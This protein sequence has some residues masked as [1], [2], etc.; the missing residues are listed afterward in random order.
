MAFRTT[1]ASRMNSKHTWT[2]VAVAALLF[3]FIFFFERHWRKPEP[4][5]QPIL[6][7]LKPAAV[8]SIQVYPAGQPG[9][10]AEHTNGNWVLTEPIRYPAQATSIEAL[11]EAL[12]TLFPAAPPLTARELRRHPGAETEYGLENPQASLVIQQ[13]NDRRQIRFG[14]LTAPGDQVFMRVVGVEDIYIADAGILKFVP[15]GTNVWRDTV[16]VPLPSLDFDRLILTN[17]ASVS[18]IELQRDGTNH[19]WRMTRPLRARASNPDMLEFLQQLQNLQVVQFVTDD[20]AP[21]LEPFGLQPAT[22]GLTLARGTNTVAQLF[23]GKTNSTGQV[24]ARRQGVPGVVTVAPELPTTLLQLNFNDFRDRHLVALPSA[25]G[26][27][28]VRGPE[29]YTLLPQTNGWRMTPAD[30]PVDAG[31]VKEFLTSLAGFEI[32]FYNSAVTEAD[33]HTNGLIA[34]AREITLRSPGL[35]GGSNAVLAQLA[36]GVTNNNRVLVARTDEETMIY[37]LK[38]ADFEQLPW[39]NWQLRDRRIWNFD[40]ADV[41]RIVMQQAGKTRIVRRLGTNSWALA[42]GSQGIINSFAIEESAHRF[43]QLAA[44]LWT[45]RAAK[46]LNR[47]GINAHTLSLTFELKNGENYTVTFGDVSPARYPYAALTLDKET[48]VFEVPLGTYA[49]VPIYLTP[50]SNTP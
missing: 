32:E 15:R 20:P 44:T 40:A 9:L 26:P 4:G 13:D 17:A 1:T 5:P 22:L 49:N 11:L 50:T 21:D 8:T 35:P 31:L 36:F 43:G 19:L 18:V 10:R 27:V 14:A 28:E 6:P 39:S 3:A 33:L 46:D 7:W 25:P 42:P 38:L 37:A 45:Q 48:W 34:P 24:F 30:F 16:F 47:Y 2:W 41:A 29:P 12:Q 23:F